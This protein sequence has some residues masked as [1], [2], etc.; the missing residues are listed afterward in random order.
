MN[1]KIVDNVCQL[2]I[3]VNFEHIFKE[4]QLCKIRK[5]KNKN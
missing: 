4:P 2:P 1:I 5:L 3:Q